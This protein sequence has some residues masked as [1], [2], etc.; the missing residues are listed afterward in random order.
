MSK[1]TTE[2]RYI[3]E[4]EAGLTQSRGYA[5]VNNIIAL[6]RPKIFNF[7]YPIFDNEYKEVLETKI[8]KHFY[9]REIG[10]ES[11]GLWKLKLDAKLNEIMPYYNQFYQSTL[12]EFNPIYTTDLYRKK[13]VEVNTADNVI[14]AQ[15]TTN[16]NNVIG[17]VTENESRNLIGNES[18]TSSNDTTN[19]DLYS[20]TPQ[21][22]L[23]NIE[24]NTYLTN[25]RKITNEND[26]EYE[27]DKSNSEANSIS[28]SNSESG[29]S[30]TNS[31]MS[32][33][34]SGNNV[35][36][37]LEHVYGYE[38]GG[39][40]KLIKEYRETFLN[41]DMMI[42]NELEELFIQLW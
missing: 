32:Q 15:E 3:C 9:T 23:T 28:K 40:S 18:G 21:G 10:L 8:L 34:K 39:V 19:K 27:I 42:I 37:Y 30:E 4:T 22:A 6:A 14:G 1:Y 5:D 13:D 2:V 35:E 12:F 29:A 7:T 11:V 31:N 41:I 26:S 20:D 33:S 16:S 24:N 38:N 17:S 36:D 25:A